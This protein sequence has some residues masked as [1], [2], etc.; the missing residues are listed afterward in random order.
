[1]THDPPISRVLIGRP[2]FA[3]PIRG[4]VRASTTRYRFFK[5]ERSRRV[6]ETDH[7]EEASLEATPFGRQQ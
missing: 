1:M 4:M 3:Q 7:S 5:E 6:G 2:G